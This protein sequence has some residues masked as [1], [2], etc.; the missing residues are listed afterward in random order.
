[1]TR[2][3]QVRIDDDNGMLL[4]ALYMSGFVI[5]TSVSG[6][7]GDLLKGPF[8]SANSYS[9][10]GRRLVFDVC[11][12]VV[13]ERLAT[14]PSLTVWTS[15]GSSSDFD[16][17][18]SSQLP[19][20]YITQVMC[21]VAFFVFFKSDSLVTFDADILYRYCRWVSTSFRSSSS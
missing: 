18:Y 1:M 3:C 20:Q 12:K 11:M 17:G 10:E 5:H 8:R 15:E 19:Q 21:L 16:S 4:P 14:V 2:C 7:L 6:Y 9:S 13:R